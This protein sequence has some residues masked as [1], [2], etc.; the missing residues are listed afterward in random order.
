MVD[1]VSSIQLISIFLKNYQNLNY[2]DYFALFL[3]QLDQ[4]N[5]HSISQFPHYL[6]KK[7]IKYFQQIFMSKVISYF[8]P[9]LNWSFLMELLIFVSYLIFC[10]FLINQLLIREALLFPWHLTLH[11]FDLEDEFFSSFS[12]IL[13]IHYWC[14]I[15]DFNKNYRK[16][17]YWILLLC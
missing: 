17:S 8:F 12:K 13:R 3:L 7:I 6:I 14:Q 1:G 2:S 16:R 5:I 15:L 9:N 11:R 4:E 10:L